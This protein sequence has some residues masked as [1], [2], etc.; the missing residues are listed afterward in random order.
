MRDRYIQAEKVHYSSRTLVS[1]APGRMER[2]LCVAAPPGERAD[3]SEPAAD[4]PHSGLLSGLTGSA[5]QSADSSGPAG[6]RPAGGTSSRGEAWRAA[7][8][9]CSMVG[10]PHSC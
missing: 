5:W 10:I 8:H 4:H 2:L 7:S 6:P 9:S 3:A 1:G